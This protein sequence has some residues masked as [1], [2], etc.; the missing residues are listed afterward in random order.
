MPSLGR[1]E[2]A[3]GRPCPRCGP[4]RSRAARASRRCLRPRLRE[5][6]NPSVRVR[7]VGDEAFRRHGDVDAERVHRDAE[8]PQLMRGR[9]RHVLHRRLGH[10]VGH[11]AR[12]VVE[13]G[14]RRD[15]DDRARAARP[16]VAD[17]GIRARSSGARMSTCI[18]RSKRFIGSSR[19]PGKVIAALFTRMSTRP[20]VAIVVATMASISSSW[21]R[22][23]GTAIAS[24]PASSMR[25]TVSSMVPGIGSGAASVARAAHATRHPRCAERDRG[26]GPDTA[27]RAGDDRDVPLELH[28][29]EPRGRA[30]SGA[31]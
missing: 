15:V 11:Q 16:H 23:V 28:A 9:H 10:P 13:R 24:P 2:S 21:A 17:D 3:S 29:R 20:N 1:R 31:R 27:A 7:E 25:W 5:A 12:E 4:C 26:G 22:F 8:W 18:T 6:P 19:S 14:H 30:R